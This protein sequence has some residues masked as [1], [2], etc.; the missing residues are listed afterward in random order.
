MN[1]KRLI[2][3]SAALLV[4]ISALP[5]FAANVAGNWTMDDKDGDGNPFTATYVL[6]QEGTVLTGSVTAFDR[7]TTSNGEGDGNKV[8]FAFKGVTRTIASKARYRAVEIKMTIKSDESRLPRS[9][10]NPQT[11]QVVGK[12]ER[13]H[14]PAVEAAAWLRCAGLT[15]ARLSSA[16]RSR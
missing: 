9:R 7:P 3:L 12:Q 15:P 8:C 13:R 5:T 16:E 4:V 2:V 6:K 11:I 1:M 14:T 10:S